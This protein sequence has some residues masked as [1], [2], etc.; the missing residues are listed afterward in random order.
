MIRTLSSLALLVTILAGCD[1]R[2]DVYLGAATSGGSGGQAGGSTGLCDP[3]R[4]SAQAVRV[5]LLPSAPANASTVFAAATCEPHGTDAAREPRIIYPSNETKLPSNLSSIHFEWSSLP[6]DQLYQIEFRGPSSSVLVYTAEPHFELGPDMWAA[7][8]AARAP[9][10]SIAVVVRALSRSDTTRV[11]ESRPLTLYAGDALPSASIYYWSTTAQGIMR[12]RFDAA[13]PAVRL[14]GSSPESQGCV[15]C[16]AVSSDGRRIAFDANSGHLQIEDLASLEPVLSSGT[17][18][19]GPGPGKMDKL[20]AEAPAAWSAFSRDGTRMALAS[21]GTLSVLDA[22][23][24]PLAPEK[25]TLTLPAKSIAAHPDWSPLGDRLVFTLGEKGGGRSV[26][27]GQIASVS[28]AND[29]LGPVEVLVPSEGPD[30]NN[31]FPSVSPDGKFVAFVNTRGK[32]YDSANAELRLFRLSDARVFPL[33][34]LNSRVNDEDDLKALGNSMPSWIST[35]SGEL[36]LSFSS[37]RAYATLRPAN[38]KLDQIW[39]AAIDPEL[40]DPAFAAFWAPFQHLAH[41]NHRAVW[42]AQNAPSSCGCQEICG[43]S[44]D[45]DCD[46]SVDEPDCLDRCETE[47]TCGDGVD[48]DCDCVVDDCPEDCEDGVDNDG[49]GAIDAADLLC[50]K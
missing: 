37:L 3:P 34:R 11:F 50:K 19:G 27:K 40:D 29:R 13:V 23:G 24:A 22:N 17:G 49:D 33:P 18:G 25:G 15:G 41:G 2:A 16:H 42:V 48:N 21:N 28:F 4:A 46:G 14:V 39:M 5:F 44:T 8:S 20:G 35:A 30:D 10:R 7:A 12:A 45:N 38:A 9:D 47:E 31:V 6:D 26:E 32:S 36:W 43:D 1:N